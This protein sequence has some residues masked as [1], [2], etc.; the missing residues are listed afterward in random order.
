MILV[1]TNGNFRTFETEGTA[2]LGNFLLMG[3]SLVLSLYS[4]LIKKYIKKYGTIIPTWI[5]MVSGTFFI[6]IINIFRSQSPV[7]I[8]TLPALS[9][10]LILYL[11]F[12]G[13]SMTYLMFNMALSHMSVSIAT[14][15]KLLIP[16]FGLFFAV[17]FL[18]EQPGVATLIGILIVV[19][20]VY[21]I[22]KES[23]K[24]EIA[25]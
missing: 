4:M 5:S 22:Q 24:N 25:G 18:G 21:I 17:I 20:S 2:I 7:Q 6:F 23:K 3:A 9:I 1:V 13:T 8:T 15:Y 12:I 11:G 19:S 14:S 10:G 16:V